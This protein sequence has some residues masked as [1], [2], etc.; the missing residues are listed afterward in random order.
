MEKK[1]INVSTFLFLIALI[2]IA[3]MGVCIYVLY[4]EKDN[5]SQ[6]IAELQNKESSLTDT[7]NT[8][9]GK[10]DTISKTISDTTT[11][12][13][14]EEK[15]NSTKNEKATEKTEEKKENDT[16]KTDTKNATNSSKEVSYSF[17]NISETGVTIVATVNGKEYKK[18]VEPSAAI[19]KTGTIELP[20]FGTVA[21]VA[22]SGGEYLTAKLYMVENDK[23]DTLGEIDLGA[24]V[25]KNADYTCEVEDETKA[26]ITAKMDSAKITNEFTQVAAIPKANVIDILD[27]GKIVYVSVTGGEYYGIRFYGLTQDYAN[28]TIKQISEIGSIN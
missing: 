10:I 22:E 3:V 6:K 7:V 28:G 11:D 20:Y 13:S 26:I 21:V 8:L 24:S 25:V 17:N 23:F 2:V 16:E 12:T 18:E 9:Q 27:I 5:Q 19:Y 4:T 15:D 14:S 1:K